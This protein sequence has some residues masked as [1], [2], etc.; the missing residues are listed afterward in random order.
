MAQLVLVMALAIAT[1]D[2]QASRISELVK[3]LASENIEEREA[4]ASS[5]KAIGARALSELKIAMLGSD[6]ELS[7]RADALIKV[8]TIQAGLPERVLKLLPH[9]PEKIV[10]DERAWTQA[11][12]ELGKLRN[13]VPVVPGITRPDLGSFLPMAVERAENRQ[14]LIRVCAIIR[15]FRLQA[16]TDALRVHL[17]GED[18]FV[19]ATAIETLAELDD[20]AAYET[21]APFLKHEDAVVRVAAVYG[22]AKID[23]VRASISLVYLLEDDDAYVRSAVV[24]C[25]PALDS[26]NITNK[27]TAYLQSAVPGVKACALEILA[28][29]N[30]T[31][32]TPE[33]RR[34]L[35]DSAP[36]VTAKAAE[37]LGTLKDQESLRDISQLLTNPNVEI[38]LSAIRAI[39][40]LGP[41]K[42]LSLITGLLDDNDE[43]VRGGA[44]QIVA[45]QERKASDVR[46]SKGLSDSSDYV[47]S[48]ALDLIASLRLDNLKPRIIEGLRSPS[49]LCRRS[50]ARAL[51]SW[52]G[53]GDADRLKTLL[54]DSD[55]EVR[56]IAARSL[57][58][59]GERTGAKTLL[60]QSTDLTPLNAIG[61][62]ELWHS[63]QSA[64]RSTSFG[65]ST[66]D[67]LRLLAT[68]VGVAIV[69][70][71][72][73]RD[74]E[75]AL[76]RKYESVAFRSLNAE[77]LVSTLRSLIGCGSQIILG[78]KELRIVTYPNALR[79][80][81]RVLEE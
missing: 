52:P 4:A 80:W 7:K 59:L 70:D 54:N 73:L 68:K 1:Q 56:M 69:W 77:R 19:K 6:Q 39:D 3:R 43:F 76:A 75:Y 34:L 31:S 53:Q 63:L 36:R 37:A 40:S 32:A 67:L 10:Q 24:A 51:S 23:S 2:A 50:A 41:S 28:K 14:T 81:K 42:H 71:M 62:P 29:V 8:I 47:R 74:C 48:V 60:D 35:K 44:L 27:A 16:A 72:E 38:R 58:Y 33:I 57:T 11:F 61:C 13:G 45:V 78:T 46:I 30:A 26:I 66:H 21:I 20:N 79:H 18:P 22:M 17:K 55:E 9:L 49:P 12:L 65:G 64:C 25:I 15:E 5:L